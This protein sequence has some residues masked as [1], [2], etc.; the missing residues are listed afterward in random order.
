MVLLNGFLYL[1]L[2]LAGAT[3][4]LI[5]HDL[6]KAE[7]HAER[8]IA[9]LYMEACPVRSSVQV[10]SAGSVGCEIQKPIPVR[11]ASTFLTVSAVAA[12]NAD[13]LPVSYDFAL[14]TGRQTK[15]REQA[16]VWLL[17]EMNQMDH[18]A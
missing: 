17:P 12:M 2:L 11:A 7:E 4:G 1:V 8:S 18:C 9:R 6:R 14:T 16:D 15:N 13:D 5:L 3:V 10:R